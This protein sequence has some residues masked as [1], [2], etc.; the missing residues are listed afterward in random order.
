IMWS[1]AAIPILLLAITVAP[2]ARAGDTP[3]TPG[4]VLITTKS[5]EAREAY[6]RGRHLTENLRISQGRTEYERA[7]QL[8][9]SFARAYLDLAG[10]Q[11][12][13]KG[14]FDTIGKAVELAST[15]SEGERLMI[16]AAMAGAN[17]D[18]ASQLRILAELAGKYPSDERA[19]ALLGNA[20]FG[21]QDYPAAV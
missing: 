13:T 14:F 15:V 18:N 3:S 2:S 19:L 17:G 10:A 9:P 8:D 11:P 4:K 5:A 20:M 7:V 6:L 16:Q 12:T 21:T 1:R